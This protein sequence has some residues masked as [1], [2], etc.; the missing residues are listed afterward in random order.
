MTGNPAA[1]RA[2]GELAAEVLRVLGGAGSALTPAEVRDALDPTGALSY[3]AVVTTLT[4]LHSKKLVNR[5]RDGRAY[6]YSA[7]ADP[8]ALTAWRM[9]RLLDAESDRASVLMRFVSTLSEHD[10]A[11]LRDMLRDHDA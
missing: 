5:R 8:A 6:R 4:R 11:L 3:S 9:G 7:S 1:R 2:P 10:E